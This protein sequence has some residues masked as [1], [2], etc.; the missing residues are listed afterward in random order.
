[1]PGAAS[2]VGPEAPCAS[3][4]AAL[5]LATAKA[6]TSSA[7]PQP[8]QP[9]LRCCCSDFHLPRCLSSLVAPAQQPA[10]LV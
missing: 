4:P 10:A 9:R 3:P 7:C 2:A 6:E 8:L 1:M 5:L